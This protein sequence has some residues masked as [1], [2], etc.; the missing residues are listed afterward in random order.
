MVGELLATRKTDGACL[1]SAFP[2]SEMLDI[3]RHGRDVGAWT[4][5]AHRWESKWISVWIAPAQLWLE[6]GEAEG[7]AC[8]ACDINPSACKACWIGTMICL[9][10][11]L[12]STV[13]PGEQIVFSVFSCKSSSSAHNQ[14]NTQY[15]CHGSM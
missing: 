15:W 3:G 11:T 6:L 14:Q 4:D 10:I 9:L 1:L 2:H 12:R 5:A 8:A 13:P 7:A